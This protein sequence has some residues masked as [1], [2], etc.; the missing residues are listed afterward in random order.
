[1]W[2]SPCPCRGSD[3][4]AGE[5][6]RS[7]AEPPPALPLRG[8]Q[9]PA[10][11]SAAP[12]LPERCHGALAAGSAWLPVRVAPDPGSRPRCCH[13]RQL[14]VPAGSPGADRLLAGLCLRSCATALSFAEV[15]V[16]LCALTQVCLV[17]C[18]L[19]LKSLRV[20]SGIDVSAVQGVCILSWM[21]QEQMQ[22]WP[23]LYA[24]AG[25]PGF[26]DL[27]PCFSG[28]GTLVCI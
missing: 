5:K 7:G 4:A 17:L 15:M 1:M 24:C 27:E 23:L 2:P 21:S 13:P 19:N 26:S 16:A 22:P 18:T 10:R 14:G 25:F 11:R 9:R 8:Q 6:Q 3:R 28:S 12:L 20:K